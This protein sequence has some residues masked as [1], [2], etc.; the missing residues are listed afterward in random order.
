[1]ESEAKF[2]PT[3]HRRPV[4]RPREYE[5]PEPNGNYYKTVLNFAGDGLKKVP[6][7]SEYPNLEILN[8]AQNQLTDIKGCFKGLSMLEVLNL[9]YNLLSEVNDSFYDLISLE[10][11]ALYHNQLVDIRGCFEGLDKLET[12]RI[13]NNPLS[14]DSIN[15]LKELEGVKGVKVDW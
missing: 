5:Q 2:T 1:M 14:D 9:G 6:D 10:V 3:G 8:L 12:I 7:L 15:Y 13:A 4:H 11:I